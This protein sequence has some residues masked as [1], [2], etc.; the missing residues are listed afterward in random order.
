MNEVVKAFIENTFGQCISLG[1]DVKMMPD[2][3]DRITVI[4][5]EPMQ[6]DA[7]VDY[8]KRIQSQT[9]LGLN[10]MIT[11]AAELGSFRAQGNL[12]EFRYGSE[13]IIKRTRNVRQF[14]LH[15]FKLI[16]PAGVDEYV[17]KLK[18]EL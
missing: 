16:V 9:P 12:L 8:I 4:G 17:D 13:R 18:C 14:L 3:I 15:A 11:L 1:K 10:E 5:L 6:I 7:L 2:V